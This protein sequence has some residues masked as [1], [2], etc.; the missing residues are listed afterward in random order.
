VDY[1]GMVETLHLLASP[2][3]AERL[4]HALEDV[5]AGRNTADRTL[6]SE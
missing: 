4:A 1:D 3:N 5:R 2:R 6:T